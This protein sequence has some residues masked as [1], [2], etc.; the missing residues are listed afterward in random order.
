MHRRG[1]E[2]AEEDKSKIAF[3]LRPL[4]FCGDLCIQHLI[5][6][7]LSLCGRAGDLNQFAAKRWNWSG[8]DVDPQ[9]DR[10]PAGGELQRDVVL[11]L[12]RFAVD[13]ELQ[14]VGIVDR[15]RHL[16]GRLHI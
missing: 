12:G 10:V 5:G 6:G 13:P 8:G 1:A 4:G 14:S 7:P 16:A 15:E 11:G 9:I 3:S 2:G